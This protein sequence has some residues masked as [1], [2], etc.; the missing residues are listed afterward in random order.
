MSN[1][2][3]VI[4]D[5]DG[6]LVDTYHAHYESWLEMARP[7]GLTF[8]EEEFA[9]TFGRTSREIIA[10]FWGDGRFSDEQIAELDDRKEAAFRRIIEHSFPA[11]PGA[12]SLLG[13][14]QSAGF[15]LG[16]G[17]SGPPE[18]VALVVERLGAED[19]FSAI[20]T[21]M[22]VTRG[23]PNPQVFLLAAERMGLPPARCAVVEDAPV[24]VKAANS[25]GMVSI[26]LASTGRTP[27]SLSEA[28]LVVAK[29]GE[30]SPR[31]IAQLIDTAAGRGN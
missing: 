20:V 22:D 28:D 27:E 8:T 21:G 6:V 5:M 3:G 2:Y 18:N 13:D 12:A 7:E 11:M 26:G 15:R 31:R 17:S 23:K 30:L 29:L 25:A 24:G 10:Y 16:V 1:T 19:R 4:F 14:L 9:P